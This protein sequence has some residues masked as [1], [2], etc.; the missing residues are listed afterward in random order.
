MYHPDVYGERT[1]EMPR[2]T[3]SPMHQGHPGFAGRGIDD[4][5]DE[6]IR[7]LEMDKEELRADNS[8]VRAQIAQVQ[9]ESS[10]LESEYQVRFCQLT[11]PMFAETDTRP[12]RMCNQAGLAE[13]QATMDRRDKEELQTKLSNIHRD[14]DELRTRSDAEKSKLEMEVRSVLG[15]IRRV[16]CEII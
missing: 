5:K 6:R 10:R 2:G 1:G 3:W 9:L 11:C 7:R 4:L 14:I 8:S 15:V 12:Q 16:L 13:Q